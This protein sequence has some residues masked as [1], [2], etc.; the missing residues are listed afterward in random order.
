MRRFLF[1]QAKSL[2]DHTRRRQ[3]HTGRRRFLSLLPSL[4]HPI[5][6]PAPLVSLS[7]FLS[8]ASEMAV[9]DSTF[10]LPDSINPKVSGCC[11]NCGLISVFFSRLICNFWQIV[12]V[13][14]VS[15]PNIFHCVSLYVFLPNNE[16]DKL[17]LISRFSVHNLRF[18]AAPSE[19][20]F[21]LCLNLKFFFLSRNSIMLSLP[22]CQFCSH[23]SLF[24]HTKPN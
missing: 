13:L 14:F 24:S 2:V 1:S 6:V 17:C 10:S 16:T 20:C 15:T 23:E 5:P 11:L 4:S 3:H 9:S 12:I 19:L 21:C 18:T 22:L 7:H 8:S